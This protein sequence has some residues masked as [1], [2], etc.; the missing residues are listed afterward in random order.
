M[1][2]PSRHESWEEFKESLKLAY[3]YAKTVTLLNT[4][5]EMMNAVMLKNRRLGISQT[6]IIEAFNKHGR[7]KM[8]NWCKK[9]YEYLREL[10]EQYSHWLC[11]PK[12]IK[13]TTVKPSGTVSLLP[14]VSH[15]IHFPHSKYYIRRI[16]INEDSE[17]VKLAKSAG[18]SV[19][20]D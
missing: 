2:Y 15:G 10:D 8:M 20:R 18:Y 5:K 9:G 16:R 17:L 3:L 12:S 7:S 1:V 19:E 6:G 13:L 14:G 4:N 11:V